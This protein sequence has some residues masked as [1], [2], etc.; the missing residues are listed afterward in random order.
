MPQPLLDFAV[1]GRNGERM[2]NGDGS[3]APHGCYPCQG[4]DRWIA[5]SVENEEQWHSLCQVLDKQE[6]MEDPRFA[7]GLGRWKHR[8]ELDALVG[9]VTLN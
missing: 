6:W 4:E 3:M 1:N 9:G 7:D 5:D 8:E 2:G